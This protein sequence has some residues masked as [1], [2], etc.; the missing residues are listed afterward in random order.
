LTA[1]STGVSALKEILPLW[2]EQLQAW[3]Q[4]GRLLEAVQESWML[5]R[6]PR[7]LLN[8]I[9][10]WAAG[11][12]RSI[13]EIVLLPNGD[14][15]GAMGAYAITTGKIYLNQDWLQGASAEPPGFRKVVTP[16]IGT[17]G[18]LRMHTEVLQTMK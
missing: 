1:T 15:S 5:K 6:T 13:P 17:P 14:I 10:Q 11:N 2:H 18:G 3:A 12:Y 4:N 8:L 16:L 7:R 9:D